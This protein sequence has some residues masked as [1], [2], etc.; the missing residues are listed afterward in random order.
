M[1]QIAG[2]RL[3]RWIIV[4]ASVYWLFLAITESYAENYD[5]ATFRLLGGLAL[6]YIADDR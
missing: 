2:S 5:A 6:A 4:A 3:L 1:K